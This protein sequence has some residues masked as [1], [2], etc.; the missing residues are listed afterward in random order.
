V[1]QLN[2]YLKKQGTS[3]PVISKI[4]KP[5]ALH[6][7]EDILEHSYGIMVARG[8]LGI[9]VEAEKV[10]LIQDELIRMARER[11]KPVIVATQ[12]M[13]SMITAHRPTRAEVVDVYNAAR[14]STDAVMLS[15][16]TAIGAHP[17]K[18]VIEMDKVLRQIEAHRFA[19]GRFF[20]PADTDDRK[21]WA[22]IPIRE[23]M[24]NAAL[25]MTRDLGLQ[26]IVVPTR[27][28]LTARAI[29]SRRPLAPVI[30]VC[31]D[32][33]LSRQFCLSW[34]IMPAFAQAEV[35]NNWKRLLLCLAESYG[36][37]VGGAP[38]L[39]VAGFNEDPALNEPSMKILHIIPE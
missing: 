38:V 21:E 30:G 27:T 18:T 31:A 5:E 14:S 28:G 16:E 13:E 6:A 25:S 36:L 33:R 20:K 24:S 22:E 26:A 7:I 39:M 35:M 23:A 19:H 17:V 8:D 2:R 29:I 37:K 3:I 12:M 4:E 34:G 1:Q 10:P 15:A 11:S 32:E 9:E